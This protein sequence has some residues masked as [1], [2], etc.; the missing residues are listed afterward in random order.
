MAEMRTTVIVSSNGRD[1]G[2]TTNGK[3]EFVFSGIPVGRCNITVSMLGFVPFVSNNILVY[4]GEETVLEIAME[5]DI[6]ALAEVTVT[7]KGD[8]E[9]P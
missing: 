8:K 1:F 2:T 4:S 5:E 7:P 9:L 6:Y 3:G